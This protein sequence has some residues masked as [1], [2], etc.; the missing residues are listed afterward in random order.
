[1][2]SLK[3]FA[4]LCLEYSKK[5]KNLKIVVVRPFNNFGPGM[6]KDDARLPAD[7]AKQV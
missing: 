2:M 4:T 6:G 7:L 5:Y 1:M 3:D